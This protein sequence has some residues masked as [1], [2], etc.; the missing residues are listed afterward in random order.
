VR[1]LGLAR[2]GFL[3]QS[4]TLY[5]RDPEDYTSLYPQLMKYFNGTPLQVLV[6]DICR[7]ELLLEVEAIYQLPQF[8]NK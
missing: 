1:Q 8:L 7:R 2:R 3:P 4:Y 5:L 6:G